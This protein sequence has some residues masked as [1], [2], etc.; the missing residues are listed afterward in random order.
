MIRER[1]T[2]CVVS[3]CFNEEEVIEPFY[4][5]LKAVLGTLPHFRHRILFVDDGSSDETLP[6]LNALAG[7]DPCVR[8]CSLSRNF[9]HQIALTAGLDAACGDAVLMMDSDLQHPPT[10][11][12]RMI[13]LWQEGNDVVSAVRESTQ[14]E[15]FFKRLTSRGFYTIL[16]RM[17]DTRIEPGAADFCLLSRR[18]HRALRQLPERHRFLRGMVSWIGFRRAFVS[19]TAAPR[20]GGKSKYT[21]GRMLALA[22]NAVYSFSAKPL[23]A[24]SRL[25]LFVTLCGAGYMAYIITRYFL[26]RDLLRGW[27]SVM[28]TLLILGGL[29]LFFIGLIGEYLARVFDEV[30]GRPLYLLKQKPLRR[31]LRSTAD[32]ASPA[33]PEREP[34]R[35]IYLEV[36]S[37]ALRASAG[38]EKRAAAASPVPSGETEQRG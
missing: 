5:A 2:L 31:R 33:I 38:V 8:V 7:A 26:F 10:L 13:E 29:Q 27:G 11:I 17:S 3:P 30:K 12:P 19:Y 25:G 28:C 15:T 22:S 23:Q 32:E 34:K 36:A 9:G 20:G 35:S 6:R 14:D 37:D 18:A 24:S 1:K 16:N 21:I 4:R